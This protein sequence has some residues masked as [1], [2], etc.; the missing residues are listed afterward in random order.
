MIVFKVFFGD[1]MIV[2]SGEDP[3]GGVFIKIREDASHRLTYEKHPLV[4]GQ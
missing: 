2:G 4:E 3:A 1:I